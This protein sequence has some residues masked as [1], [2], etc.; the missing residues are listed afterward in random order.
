V[1][2]TTVRLFVIVTFAIICSACAT[3]VGRPTQTIPVSST[4][5]DASILIVDEAGVEVFKGT[6]PTTVTLQKSSGKYW[7]KKSFAVTISK[8]G[9][10]SQT[11]PI[12]ATANGWY[13]AGNIV[14]GGLIGWFIVDPL[15]GNMY[16]LSPDAVGG[17]LGASSSHNNRARDGSITIV[18][19]DDVPESLRGKMVAVR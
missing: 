10:Q 11:V 14:F 1:Y 19:I 8:P 5:S 17:S 6:T 12:A 18:L 7:G 13:I 9:Y 4:P 16:T 2:A 3:I 15:N